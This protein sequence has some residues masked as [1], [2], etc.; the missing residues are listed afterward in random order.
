MTIHVKP[1]DRLETDDVLAVATPPHVDASNDPGV[2][3]S[4]K[5]LA[6]GLA[7]Q[8]VWTQYRNPPFD[9]E[10]GRIDMLIT[11]DPLE[12]EAFQPGDNCERCREGNELAIEYLKQHPETSVTLV[13][14][15]TTEVW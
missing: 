6:A 4:W 12:V 7:K 3:E 2:M 9:I 15:H 13:N 10:F 11:G 5:R 14:I 8:H 1:G